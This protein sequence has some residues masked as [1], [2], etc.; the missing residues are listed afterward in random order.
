MLDSQFILQN[1]LL[2]FG[3]LKHL[4]FMTSVPF[5][6]PFSTRAVFLSGQSLNVPK[7]K[8]AVAIAN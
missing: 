7:I 8:L 2:S 1:F 6:K 5:N 4:F 3:T